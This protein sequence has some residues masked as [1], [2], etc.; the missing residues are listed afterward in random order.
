M[1][2]IRKAAIALAE[3]KAMKLEGWTE[4]QKIFNEQLKERMINKAKTDSIE[5]LIE[6]SME[7]ADKYL[8][9]F[10]NN[11]NY[12]PDTGLEAAVMQNRRAIDKSIVEKAIDFLRLSTDT[13]LSIEM[14][15]KLST[16]LLKWK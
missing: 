12:A 7:D 6:R 13:E 14:R 10:N 15:S 8:D 2:D 3:A 4:Q 11:Y 9:S 16:F 5:V 1:E